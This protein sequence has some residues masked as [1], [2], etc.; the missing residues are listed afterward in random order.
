M[1]VRVFCKASESSYLLANQRPLQ[2]SL[3]VCCLAWPAISDLTFSLIIPSN[4]SRGY[5][6]LMLTVYVKVYDVQK[7]SLTK[8]CLFWIIQKSDN[9]KSWATSPQVSWPITSLLFIFFNKLEGQ[10]LH[11]HFVDHLEHCIFRLC[12]VRKKGR[13]G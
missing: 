6:Q 10:K 8:R 13:G 12:F 3:F 9:Q 2:W 1:H 5:S 4:V 11:P 7:Q